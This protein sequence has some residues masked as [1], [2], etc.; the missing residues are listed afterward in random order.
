MSEIAAVHNNGLAGAGDALRR[1]GVA[2][3]AFAMV[4]LGVETLICARDAA[5]VLGPQYNV[6]PVI[7]W[8][9]AISWLSYLFGAVWVACGVR[10]SISLRTAV[11]EPLALASLAW[12]FPGRVSTPDFL[13][14]AGRYLLALSLIVFGVD[15]FLALIGIGELLPGWIP[16][17]AFWVAFFGAVF[18]A[19]GLSMGFNCLQQWGAA[20][21]GLMFAIWVVALHLPRVLGLYGIPGALHDPDEWSKSYLSPSHCGEVC[22]R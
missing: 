5:Q 10:L 16:W 14:R 2:V 21:V 11:F 13:A 12:L 3:F 20:G 19:G 4:A 8:L 7:P 15:H 17:H 22:G 9:P 1:I 18:I 6:I